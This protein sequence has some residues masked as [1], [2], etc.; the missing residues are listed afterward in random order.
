MKIEVKQS[1][2]INKRVTN[3]FC[4]KDVCIKCEVIGKDIIIRRNM[5][6]DLN[7]WEGK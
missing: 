6:A 4:G 7:K 1:E 2:T 5:E 3:S